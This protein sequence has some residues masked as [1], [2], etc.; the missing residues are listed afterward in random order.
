MIDSHH[1]LPQ[2][3]QRN[4][5]PILRLVELS[6]LG[7]AC[8]KRLVQTPNYK[9]QYPFFLSMLVNFEYGPRGC[10]GNVTLNVAIWRQYSLF[11]TGYKKTDG[12]K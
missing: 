6:K 12:V 8:S 4:T 3:T 11:P 9:T 5:S 1:G 7:H 10:T 2:F